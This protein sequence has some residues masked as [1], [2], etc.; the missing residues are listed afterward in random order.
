MAEL[1]TQ[2]L[3]LGGGPGGYPAAFEAADH[4]MQVT[5]VDEGAKPGGVCLNRGCIPSKALLHVAKLI[6]ESKE[7][8]DWGL[9][10]TRPKID[11]NKLREF[12]NN[13]IGKMAG[14]IVELCKLRGVTLVQGRGTFLDDH[15]L[16]VKKSD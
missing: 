11:L 8:A 14:G 12:K 10:F 5:L 1:Q 2:L 15:T 13:V 16:E 4:G 6:N 7:A 3:V 9:N